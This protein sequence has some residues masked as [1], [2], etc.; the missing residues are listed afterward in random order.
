MK[1]KIIFLSST[2]CIGGI[3]KA[4]IELLNRLDY[5][6]YDVTLFLE[7]KEGEL[8]N[9][10]NKNVK[11]Y[12][13]NLSHNKNVLIRKISNGFKRIKYLLFNYMKYDFACSY[14]TYSKTCSYFS[15]KSSNNNALYV[16]GDYTL[17]FNDDK[18]TK[19]FFNNLDIDKFKRVVF[20]SNES[21]NNLIKIMSKI[22]NNSIV[23][24]NFINDEEIIKLSSKE[25][26]NDKCTFLYL[27]RLDEGVKQTSK[28]LKVMKYL[29]E[30]DIDANLWIVGD[31]P[32]YD[33]YK[34]YIDDNNLN[35]VIK[36]FGA[37]INPYP[38]L[39]KCD[40]LVLT[41]L[42]EGF[43]V[44]FLEALTLN[45]KIIS[46]LDLSDD[47]IKISDYGYIVS[48]DAGKMK[49]EIETILKD[50]KKFKSVDFNKINQERIK[51]IES[52]IEGD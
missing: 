37:K 40:Y 23:I 28:M 12:N 11:V 44:T 9:K 50:D 5:N 19:E 22:K 16:H 34:K 25:N 18:K 6:K 17:E 41:S 38:Y 43:P 47:E 21:K 35:E 33:E 32:S 1:K 29:K 52:L 4:L 2:L 14:A 36:M 7:N 10:I 45:K 39:K 42:H 15:L 48:M 49:K 46:T 27:G 13:Y 8:L 20:V 3:E 31:G 51:K 24:N 30:K 26:I